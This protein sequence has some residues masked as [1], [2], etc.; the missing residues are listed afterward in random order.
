M[1]HLCL[2]VLLVLVVSI[3]A[4]GCQPSSH[5]RYRMYTHRIDCEA[6]HIGFCDD[7]DAVFLMERPTH[8]SQWY[9]P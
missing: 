3:V 8:L 5:D 1:K 6:N 4:T 7:L 2:L 9:F